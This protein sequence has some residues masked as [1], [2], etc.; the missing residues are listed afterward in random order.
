MQVQ[1]Y[2]FFEGRCKE[3]LAFYRQALG[4]QVDMLMRFNDRPEAPPPGAVAPGSEE[5]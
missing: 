5:R 3:A 2:L 4:A 1:P